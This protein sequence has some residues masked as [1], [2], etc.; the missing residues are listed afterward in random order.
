MHSVSEK[1]IPE[2]GIPEKGIQRKQAKPD[3]MLFPVQTPA[4]ELLTVGR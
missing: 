3:A 2:K 4:T 1:G